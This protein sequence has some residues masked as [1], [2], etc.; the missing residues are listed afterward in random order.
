MREEKNG[1]VCA[2]VVPRIA[3]TVPASG[4]RGVG[5]E[6]VRKCSVVGRSRRARLGLGFERRFQRDLSSIAAPPGYL[7]D[8][9]QGI[10]FEPRMLRKANPA[11][12]NR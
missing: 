1:S 2:A 5:G 4:S 6:V 9:G 10:P 3:L 8:F 12:T 11:R 7:A